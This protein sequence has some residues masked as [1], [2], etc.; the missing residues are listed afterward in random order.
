MKCE[1]H[2]KFNL[3]TKNVER[4]GFKNASIIQLQLVSNLIIFKPISPAEVAFACLE[5]PIVKKS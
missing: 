4:L 3:N 1:P 5:I 2:G